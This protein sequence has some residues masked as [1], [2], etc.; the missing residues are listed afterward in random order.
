M[1]DKSM[2]DSNDQTLAGY[3]KTVS[4]YIDTSPQNVGGDLKNWIDKNL[5]KLDQSA[6][7]LE[8]GSG[9]LLI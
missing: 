9:S 4:K 7:I 3:N 2:S 5:S 6:K 1:Y 8:I